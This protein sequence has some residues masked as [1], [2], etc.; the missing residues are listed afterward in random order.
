MN[1]FLNMYYHLKYFNDEWFEIVDKEGHIIGRAPR[2][3]CHNGRSFYMH[4]VV[5]LLIVNRKGDMLLQKRSAGKD[6]QPGKWDTAVGGHVNIGESI[7]D[8][9]IRE[10][11]EELGV[12][13]K[14]GKPRFL[15]SYLMKS[16]REQELVNTFL[17]QRNEKRYMFSRDEISEVRYWALAK[18]RKNIGQGVFTPNFEDEFEKFLVIRNKANKKSK[19]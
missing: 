14:P 3:V 18:I 2:K 11:S 4:R 1:F 8:A 12:R 6:I 9:L 15:Y 7:S 19:G 13:L 10:T 16:D 5:H 17:V